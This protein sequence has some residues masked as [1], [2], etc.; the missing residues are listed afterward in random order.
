MFKALSPSVI[1][2]MVEAG[3]ITVTIKPGW[4]DQGH[5]LAKPANIVYILGYNEEA[6][7]TCY[8]QR[9]GSTLQITNVEPAK[10]IGDRKSL[11]DA[12]LYVALK[13]LVD[14]ANSIKLKRLVIDSYIP[15]LA[16]HMLDLGFNVTARGLASGSRGC[17]V[18]E[19]I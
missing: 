10:L 11:V 4:E 14:M 18:F 8:Y 16:D 3:N 12:Y 17:R 13:G 2:E 19:R 15:A 9:S 5:W 6:I 7:F 1:D